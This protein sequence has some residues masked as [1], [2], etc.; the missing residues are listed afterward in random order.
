MQLWEAGGEFPL[1]AFQIIAVIRD[2]DPCAERPP[3]AVYIFV[4][5]AI[6]KQEVPCQNGE[7]PVKTMEIPDGL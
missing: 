7:Y 3:C 2:A 1:P 5:I 4:G 6:L